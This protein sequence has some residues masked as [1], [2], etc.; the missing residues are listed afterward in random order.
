MPKRTP[1]STRPAGTRG[2]ATRVTG[3]RLALTALV[4]AALCWAAAS[5]PGATQAQETTPLW[6]ADVTVVAL[7]NGATGAIGPEDFSNQAGSAGLT[8]RW[9]Y[10]YDYDNKLRLSFTEG[11]DVAG[12]VL[13][14]DHLNLAFSEEDSGNGSFTWTD[15][16]VDWESGQTLTARIVAASD[17]DTP[18]TGLPKV[19][20]RAQVDET[21]TADT[22][23]IA[24]RDGLDS[25]SYSYQ[26]QAD[27]AD[28]ATA[29]NSTYT[30]AAADIG[31]ALTVKVSFTDDNGNGESLTS[32]PTAAVIPANTAAAGKPD[33]TGSPKVRQ[34]LTAGVSAVTDQDGLTGAEYAYQWTGDDADI[35]G[36][37]GSGYKLTSN[38]IG[39]TIKVVVSFQDDNGNEETLTS[40]PT[41][42]VENAPP[43]APEIT[44]ARRAH[45][46]M[47]KVN[48]NDVEDATSYELQYHQYYLNWVTLPHAPLNYEAHYDG[49]YA[50]V[51]GLGYESIYSFRVRVLNDAGPSG[52]SETY[53]NGYHPRELYGPDTSARPRLA[54]SPSKPQDLAASNAGHLEVTLSWSA[55]ADSSDSDVTGYR[56]EYRPADTKIWSFLAVAEDTSYTHT[57]LSPERKL[58]YRVSAFNS[59]ARGQN[60]ERVLGRSTAQAGRGPW[61][62]PV[63]KVADD[64]PLLPAGVDWTHGDRLRLMF[65]TSGSRNANSDNIEEYNQFVQEAAANGHTGIQ[66]YGS[67][68]RVLASTVAVDAIDNTGTNWTESNPGLPVYWLKGTR[69]A[70]DYRDLYDGEW[71][72]PRFVK[73][74]SGHWGS[75]F[76]P[77]L[78]WARIEGGEVHYIFDAARGDYIYTDEHGVSMYNRH[79]HGYYWATY[80]LEEVFQ[81]DP[82]PCIATGSTNGGT[83]EYYGNFENCG[84][85]MTL[86]SPCQEV[87]FGRPTRILPEEGG[88]L[89]PLP[90]IDPTLSFGY[91][92]TTPVFSDEERQGSPE[93]S[94]WLT[95]LTEGVIATTYAF[96]AISPIFEVEE[97]PALTVADAEAT[98][99]NDATL[100]FTVTL[101]PAAETEVTVDYATQDG[102]ATAGSDYT[103]TSGTLTFA[104]GE[105]SKTVSVPIIDDTISDD[106][107][108]FKLLLSNAS[109]ADL[110]DAEATG[111]INNTEAN[112]APTGLPTITGTSRVRETL[113]ADIAGISDADGLDDVEFSYQWLADNAEIDSATA[114]S[115]TLA[116]GDAGMRISVKVAFNDNA[117]NAESLTSAQHGPVTA[118]VP[119]APQ[120]LTVTQGTQGGELDVSWQ[121]PRSNGG[122][123]ITGYTVQWKEAADSWETDVDVS[124]ATVTDTTHLITGLTAGTAYTVRATASSSQG[125]G[126]PSAEATASAPAAT[127]NPA[128]G[129]PTISGTAQVG[130][131]LTADTSAIADDD[132][133]TKVSYSYQWTADGTDIDG[134]TGSSHTLTDADQ[135]KTI[136]VKVSFTDDADNEESLTSAATEAVEAKPNTAPT[137]L[138]TISGTAQMGQTLTADT[139]GIADADGLTNV[140]YG[141]QWAADGTDI[142]G[143]TGSSHTLTD[144]DQGKTIRVRVSFTDDEGNSETLTSA[145]TDAVAAKPAPLTASILA[146]PS[147]HAGENSFTFELRFSEE[148]ELS[149]L[150]LRD[151]VFTETGGEVTGASRL[152]KPSNLRWQIVV[153][154]DSDAEVTIVLPPTTDC[155]AQGAICTGGG[156]KL[157]GRV[158]LTVNGPEPPPQEEEEQEEAGDD[159]QAPQS[160]PPAPTSLTAAVNA[161]G[162]IVLSWTAPGDDSVTGYQIL[163]RRPTEDE[164]T[165]LVYVADTRSTA[166]TF[167]DT[168]VTAGVRHVYRVKAINGAGL[169][170]WSNYV[171]PTP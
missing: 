115:Y 148:V 56:V 18:P 109:G 136:K 42:A 33:I 158:E 145:A 78:G 162:H 130:E 147:S 92:E 129:A 34:T 4:L 167:A 46:G 48:W 117:G 85:Y 81:V 144:A 76:E 83:A 68:F 165:L 135:G 22:S 131:I 11:A 71:D 119:T 157:S 143:A 169:S 116:D 120:G 43:E 154:P 40:D 53:T 63:H 20:G 66:E 82:L 19:T 14:V 9:L 138:P 10:H 25:A 44:M 151:H 108:T 36:A 52:W 155:G 79:C 55:P 84:Y 41:G 121:A 146:A 39:K 24:D 99:G 62:P 70:D 80:A 2:P 51:D 140:S 141:Y 72:D 114:S 163:R 132:G 17:G 123:A 125:N 54:G 31:K 69:V 73:S 8:A 112:T 133:L 3:A 93:W 98:E 87:S 6:S 38:E 103:I 89:R 96:Y 171:N 15:V 1:A 88:N 35:E 170:G 150:T 128:T 111:T 30:P 59:D 49:S 105:T 47:H 110:G 32:L 126:A 113:T 67:G 91:R 23:D 86:G 164:A 95:N 124:E 94:V 26:W 142:D 159:Q 16:A 90:G 153:E 160:P 166:T 134:A 161:D 97:D 37:T 77:G 137:G 100:D 58:Y 21:L 60:T 102:T 139:T 12:H 27:G 29:T 28:I 156:R 104:A 74:K 122:S 127:N 61:T 50:L 107:E 168:G 45:V 149:Y 5:L 152:D 64:W 75:Y 65:I 57:G 106:G 101:F 118:T 13:Q 7:E